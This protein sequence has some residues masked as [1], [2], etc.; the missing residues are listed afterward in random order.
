MAI[1]I[2]TAIYIEKKIQL[3]ATTLVVTVKKTRLTVKCCLKKT[4]HQC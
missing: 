2:Y 1:Y 4:I 3:S